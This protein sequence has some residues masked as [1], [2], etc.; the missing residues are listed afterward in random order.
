MAWSPD[1][2]LLASSSQD[3]T[4]KLWDAATGACKATLSDGV[5]YCC[6]WSPDRGAAVHDEEVLEAARLQAD[7]AREVGEQLL[8]GI[9]IPLADAL[10]ENAILGLRPGN[11][12]P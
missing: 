9:G 11:G 12:T 10:R 5:Y 7:D 3:K 8:G 4:L 6:A 1:G 2:R